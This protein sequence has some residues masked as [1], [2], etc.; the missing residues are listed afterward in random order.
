MDVLKHESEATRLEA[1]AVAT[2][3]EVASATA[4]RMGDE[5]THLQ[6]QNASY[7]EKILRHKAR[8]NELEAAFEKALR[9]S[10][11]DSDAK[12]S[13]VKRAFKDTSAK[14]AEARRSLDSVRQNI[15]KRTRNE[16]I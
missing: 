1:D 16:K 15:R 4:E 6:A 8:E 13:K 7:R 14:L 10:S 12:L 9:E 2:Q 3:K 5:I 11:A